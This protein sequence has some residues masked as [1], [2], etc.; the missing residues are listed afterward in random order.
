MHNPELNHL[1]Q[2]RSSQH[3]NH[4]LLT[5]DTF[6]RTP[7]PGMKQCVAVVHAGTALGAAFTQYTAEFEAGGEL[8]STSAQRFLYVLEGEITVELGQQSKH[9]SPPWLRLYS[10]RDASTELLPQRQA[11]RL[12][13]KSIIS[14]WLGSSRLAPSFP[15]K[16]RLPRTPSTM[17]PTCM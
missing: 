14:R 8:G 7:L 6:V 12:W 11:A 13:S 15:A 17:I 4:L 5:P 1:G 10:A 2:T 9:A 16:T 3:R